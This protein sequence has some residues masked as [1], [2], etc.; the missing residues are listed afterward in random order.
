MAEAKAVL[1]ASVALRMAAAAIGASNPKAAQEL[2]AKAEKLYFGESVDAHTDA[3][4]AIKIWEEAHGGSMSDPKFRDQ[5]YELAARYRKMLADRDADAVKHQAAQQQVAAD[6]RKRQQDR[7]IRNRR[8]RP[9][10]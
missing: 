6:R 9:A 10:H 8:G 4:D 3:N 5:M 7:Q 2:T 1:D